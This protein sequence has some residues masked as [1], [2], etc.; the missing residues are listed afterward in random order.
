MIENIFEHPFVQQINQKI[1]NINETFEISNVS[2][3]EEKIC[4]VG[5]SIP[6][7]GNTKSIDALKRLG[8]SKT[9][10]QRARNG[11]F[12]QKMELHVNY[13][14]Y[15]I[16]QG[17]VGKY[18]MLYVDNVYDFKRHHVLGN[19]YN[20]DFPIVV[21]NYGGRHTFDEKYE[22]GFIE[23]K[24]VLEDE[25]PLT[26]EEMYPKNSDAFVYGWIDREGNTYACS[27]E[28]HYR[29][30]E[31]LC[32]EIGIKGWNKEQAL[33]TAGWIKIS[34]KP[35]YTPDT[36]GSQEIYYDL[37]HCKATQAQIDKLY[38]LGLE[39]DRTLKYMLRNM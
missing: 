15:A 17:K 36:I 3:Q 37:Q 9:H 20:T 1:K 18:S 33:E 4:S 38:D 13:D 30:A 28:S 8:F 24:E 23:I 26:R 16:Y 32:Q 25:E 29:A 31:A 22:E 27:F 12:I 39:N 7:K 10:K 14:K 5:I 2:Y 19:P 35:P 11:S 6:L 34:R 21:N